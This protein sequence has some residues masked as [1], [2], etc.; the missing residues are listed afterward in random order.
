SCRRAALVQPHTAPQATQPQRGNAA[1]ARRTPRPF[2]NLLRSERCEGVRVVPGVGRG[3]ARGQGPPGLLGTATARPLGQS[4]GPGLHDRPE[5][6]LCASDRPETGEGRPA[7]GLAPVKCALTLTRH[8]F[9][10]LQECHGARSFFSTMS[11]PY[12]VRN[13][14]T[15]MIVATSTRP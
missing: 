3:A 10:R 7:P 9:G 15:F 8:Q 5:K 2:A 11:S 13:C 6:Y 14:C 12:F 1:H 4:H